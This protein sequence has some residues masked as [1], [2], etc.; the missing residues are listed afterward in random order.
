MTENDDD[1]AEEPANHEDDALG[2]RLAAARPAPPAGYRG[3]LRR[4]LM[5]LGPP[6]PRPRRLWA[7]VAGFAAAG[8]ILLAVGALSIAGIGPLGT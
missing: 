2:R 6:P 5:A 8:L 3:A 4:R 1:L 7:L